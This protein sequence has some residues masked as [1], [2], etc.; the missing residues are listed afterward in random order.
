MSTYMYSKELV[1]THVHSTH[2]HSNIWALSNIA[3]MIELKQL[4]SYMYPGF[5]VDG[6]EELNEVTSHGLEEAV[7]LGHTYPYWLHH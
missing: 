3:H 1:I 7:W 6:T 4:A 2:V 5:L